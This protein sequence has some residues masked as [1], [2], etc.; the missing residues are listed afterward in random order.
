MKDITFRKWKLTLLE[1]KL[2]LLESE[3]L[4][5][6]YQE[7]IYGCRHGSRSSRRRCTE[8]EIWALWSSLLCGKG[9]TITCLANLLWVI[10]EMI[11][12]QI[13][14]LWL[15]CCQHERAATCPDCSVWK[16]E[17]HLEEGGYMLKLCCASLRHIYGKIMIMIKT[18]LTR[19]EKPTR[20]EVCE[21][22]GWL[23]GRWVWRAPPTPPS[24]LSLQS[25]Y[26][27][28]EI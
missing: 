7:E 19:W 6:H 23:R 2:T 26:A 14:S 16:G 25:M 28:C 10:F 13:F 5:K 1:C 18:C 21:L 12:D 24:W 20:C 4:N 15:D 27:K 8:K 22:V 17:K 3:S 9:W 11:Y